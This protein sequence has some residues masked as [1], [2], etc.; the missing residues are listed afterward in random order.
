MQTMASPTFSCAS[1]RQ[2]HDWKPEFIGKT[3]RCSCGYVMK[4]PALN[5]CQAAQ[6]P[7]P[8]VPAPPRQPN[9]IAA[10]GPIPEAHDS[11]D[12]DTE[13]ELATTGTYGEEDL[14]K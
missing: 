8:H 11:R 4:I 9:S 5:V 14:T 13:A 6:E 2:A 10:F 1:C 12:A 3:A 7:I